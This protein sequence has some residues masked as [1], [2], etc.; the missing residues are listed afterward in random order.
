MKHPTRT[1]VGIL[2]GLLTAACLAACGGGPADGGPSAPTTAR[3]ELIK[4]A[5]AVYADSYHVDITLKVGGTA[6]VVRVDADPAT[7]VMRA[8]LTSGRENRDVVIIGTEMWMKQDRP[9]YAIAAGRWIHV[10]LTRSGLSPDKVKNQFG[11]P[12][13]SLFQHVRTVTRTGAGEYSGTMSAQGFSGEL[14][15]IADTTTDIRFTATVRDG[16]LAVLNQ[17]ITIDTDRLPT[18]ISDGV[19]TNRQEFS[20][21]GAP[22]TVTRPPAN[23]VSEAPTEMYEILQKAA[24]G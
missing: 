15:A 4:A 17:T 5:D 19:V 24:G 16:K 20:A 12:E 7:A 3:E 14:T 9:I 10:D 18:S 11:T 22:V 2:V 6:S 21:F 23:E 1:T 8:V 13:R